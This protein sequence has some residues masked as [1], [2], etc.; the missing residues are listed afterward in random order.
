MIE[1]VGLSTAAGPLSALLAD[2]GGRSR[3]LLVGTVT[4]DTLLAASA[5]LLP[6]EGGS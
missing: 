4:V 1:D 3:W 2:T 5:A 6:L